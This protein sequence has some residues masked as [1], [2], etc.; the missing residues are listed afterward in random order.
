MNVVLQVVFHII[1]HPW[2]APLVTT[3]VI[4]AV[5]PLFIGYMSLVERKVLADFQ[6]RRGPCVSALAG[7]F[8]PSPMA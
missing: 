5:A 4:L 2:F 8:S 6:S 7:C 1:G 3:L